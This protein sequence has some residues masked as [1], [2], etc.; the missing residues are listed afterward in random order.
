MQLMLVSEDTEIRLDH[1]N[2]PHQISSDY[3][4]VQ[5]AALQL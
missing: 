3:G 4:V 2:S 5:D 1:A